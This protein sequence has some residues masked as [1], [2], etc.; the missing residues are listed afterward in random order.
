VEFGFLN[1]TR[2]VGVSEAGPSSA[3]SAR[4]EETATT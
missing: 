2:I 1:A 3:V 4:A